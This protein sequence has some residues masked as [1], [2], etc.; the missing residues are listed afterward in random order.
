M[1]TMMMMRMTLPTTM[2]LLQLRAEEGR[3]KLYLFD[4]SVQSQFILIEPPIVSFLV[5]KTSRHLP[6]SHLYTENL[7]L[8]N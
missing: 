5:T 2:Y 6:F 7:I 4:H 8:V 1:M 3:K